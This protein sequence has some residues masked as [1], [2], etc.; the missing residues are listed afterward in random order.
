M[1]PVLRSVLAIVAGFL[2]INFVIIAF[3]LTAVATLHL[4]SSQPTSG[5][6]I[7]NVTYSFLACIAG[8]FVCGMVAGRKPLQHA[9]ALSCIMLFFGIFSYLHY[10]G[11]QPLWY[12]LM[13]ISAPPALALA[14]AAI[15]QRQSARAKT[16]IR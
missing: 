4:K 1:P 10:K 16:H 5:Y 15:F 9:L 8:G 3:T 7:F 2:C 12:Q 6:L 11:Q 13:M 14:G